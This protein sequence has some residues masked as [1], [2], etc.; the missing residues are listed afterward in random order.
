MLYSNKPVKYCGF[1]TNQS[2]TWNKHI[3]GIVIQ[4]NHANAMLYKVREV[5]T[6]IFKINNDI[7]S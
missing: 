1:K 2:L 7:I 6:S 3:N 4:L 5:N